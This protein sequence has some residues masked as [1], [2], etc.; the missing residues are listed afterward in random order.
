MKPIS[1]TDRFSIENIMLAG[2]HFEVDCDKLAGTPVEMKMVVSS[3]VQHREEAADGD[4]RRFSCRVEVEVNASLG[5]ENLL[6]SRVA[7]VGWFRWADGSPLAEEAARNT[8]APAY[9]YNFCREQ[10]ADLGRRC[11]LQMFLPPT[12][13]AQPVEP[14]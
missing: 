4:Y 1:Q 10:T 14:D 6:R 13:L 8:M 9:L 11:G 5:G 12:R 2:C 3:D 7:Y